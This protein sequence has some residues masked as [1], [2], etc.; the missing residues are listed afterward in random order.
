MSQVTSSL[1]TTYKT[2]PIHTITKLNMNSSSSNSPLAN[3]SAGGSNSLNTSTSE[4]LSNGS[5]RINAEEF[6]KLD[7]LLEDLLAEVDQPI[8]FNKDYKH[9]P[10]T[11]TYS[12]SITH[13]LQP[14]VQPQIRTT[15]PAVT[16]T[17]KILSNMDDIERSVDWLNE[18]KERLR[19]RKEMLNA[20]ISSPKF[21]QQQQNSTMMD[22]APMRY[23]DEDQ[24]GDYRQTTALT[25]DYYKQQPQPQP[26]PMMMRSNG[27]QY[28]PTDYTGN[29]LNNGYYVTN[30]HHAANKPPVSPNVRNLYSP[31]VNQHI[32]N[33]YNANISYN[34]NKVRFKN[35]RRRS[36]CI[37]S[38][39]KSDHIYFFFI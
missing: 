8:M 23:M 38:D 30:G 5:S 21:Q 13:H 3:G 39:A 36:I 10:P 24:I 22:P 1:E 7:A 15:T 25:R 14:P 2:I 16:K 37:K 27:Y 12:T 34:N 26:M 32:S 19:S 31:T 35:Q 9:N 11:R 28:S 29:E 20:Q 33:G 17:T 4:S 6:A 18:Q